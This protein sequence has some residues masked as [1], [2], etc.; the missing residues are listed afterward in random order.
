MIRQHVSRKSS[1]CADSIKC[2]YRKKT[3]F[4]ILQESMKIYLLSKT[5]VSIT[6]GAT[7]PCLPS[8]VYALAA[9]LPF[10]RWMTINKNKSKNSQLQDKSWYIGISNLLFL[11]SKIGSCITI[12]SLNQFTFFQNHRNQ[13]NNCCKF[14]I[15]KP[16]KL[17]TPSFCITYLQPNMFYSQYYFV[18]RTCYNI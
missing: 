16:Q 8:T 1:P 18:F 6:K 14:G 10:L 17:I 9:I 4:Y 12:A 3:K 13:Y 11:I 7:I 5:F 15:R 2:R